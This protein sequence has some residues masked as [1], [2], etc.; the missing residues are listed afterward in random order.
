[1]RSDVTARQY[2]WVPIKKRQALFGLPKNRQQ[3]SVK[4]TL[5]R[6]C[7]V[8]KVQGLPIFLHLSIIKYKHTFFSFG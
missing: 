3:P 4:K 2:H 7:T 8:Y 5:S 1:M 6:G